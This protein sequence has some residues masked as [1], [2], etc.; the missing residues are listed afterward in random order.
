MRIAYKKRRNYKYV[1][2][3]YCEIQLPLVLEQEIR[4]R[5][6]NLTQSGSLQLA[7][8]YAWD[9]ASGPMPDLPSVMRASL[10]HDA[11]YQLMREGKLPDSYRK[12]ADQI[13]RN[14]CI[15]DG[16]NV[17][18]ANWV[19]YCVRS[20]GRSFVQSDLKWLKSKDTQPGMTT[21][22]SIENI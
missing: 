22:S 20:F 5:F 1:L 12:Q 3:Q 6:I 17:V 21:K 8:H 13:L 4:T 16:M 11:L 2:A 18:L 7:Q 19:Y 15:A 14:L 9:G 10:V